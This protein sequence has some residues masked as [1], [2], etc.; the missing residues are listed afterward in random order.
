[1]PDFTPEQI[2]LIETMQR[3]AARSKSVLQA[4]NQLG[5]EHPPQKV[6]D[7]LTKIR[8]RREADRIYGRNIPIDGK[9][10][11]RPIAATETFLIQR[12]KD[13][14]IWDGQLRLDE[15]NKIAQAKNLPEWRIA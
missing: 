5:P 12:A 10:K 8:H 1:M 4:V 2:A 15:L 14:G 13:W 11:S 6:Y 7:A 9:K 3:A